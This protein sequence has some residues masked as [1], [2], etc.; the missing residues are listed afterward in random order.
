[1][2]DQK[3][4]TDIDTLA[5]FLLKLRAAK[6]FGNV[7]IVFNDGNIVHIDN[8]QTFKIDG[9]KKLLDTTAPS[10]MSLTDPRLEF[11]DDAKS[12]GFGR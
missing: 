3:Q 7:Q 11:T 2:P 10:I 12:R 4:N 9:I 5:R 6:V 8:H 1:M